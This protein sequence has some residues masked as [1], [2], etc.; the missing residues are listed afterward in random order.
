VYLLD[1]VL[2]A[3]D[4]SVAALLWDRAIC[5][6]LRSKTRLVDFNTLP[7]NSSPTAPLQWPEHLAS[8]GAGALP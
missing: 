1:D 4:A 6:M 2:A 7:G 8:Q 5:G 3:V